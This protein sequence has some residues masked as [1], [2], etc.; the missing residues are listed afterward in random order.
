MNFRECS[1]LTY[2][3]LFWL[4]SI[5]S[6]IFA[7]G[8]RLAVKWTDG[9]YIMQR[10]SR[11]TYPD[12]EKPGRAITEW[13][14]IISARTMIVSLN[15]SFITVMWMFPN[16]LEEAAPRWLDM[17]VRHSNL[18]IHKFAGIWLNGV[19]TVIHV[20]LLFLPTLLDG[21]TKEL[22]YD[23]FDFSN[24]WD[25]CVRN[26]SSFISKDLV[27]YTWDEL[28]RLV[29]A[30]LVFCIMMPVSRAD[31]MLYK[32]YSLAMGIHALA[33]FLFM[34]DMVRKNSHPL[35]WR[36]NLPFIILYVIDRLFATFCY[37]VHRFTVHEIRQ[38]SES[39]FVLFG[40]LKNVPRTGQGC[41]DNYWLLHRFSSRTPCTPVFQ[42]AHPYTAFQ[43]WDP[44][45][46]HVW[47]VGFVINVNLRNKQ[48]WSAW[49]MKM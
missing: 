3:K 40:R 44:E 38:C 15:I 35:C 26:F 31:W 49:L 46:E 36:F 25:P 14:W 19:V 13:F 34:I 5:L 9:D 42:R 24:W 47:N 1:R 28:F 6:I 16:F 41:G 30:I 7:V 20:V 32:S 2:T 48:S 10:D 39:S 12:T 29:L 8:D 18:V 27:I 43:N 33:G 45:T 37:R 11:N 22:V 17:D 23:G 21:T 4:V